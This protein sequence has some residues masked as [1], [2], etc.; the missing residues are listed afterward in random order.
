[1][2]AVVQRVSHASVTIVETSGLRESGRIGRGLL[3]LLGVRSDDTD[4]D[5]A[6]LADKIAGLRLFEDA[7]GR[8]NLALADVH[9]SVLAVPNFTL[10]A[11]CRKGRRPS[12]ADAASGM[13]AENLFKRF[14]AAVAAHGIPVETGEFGAD[15]RVALENAGPVTIV[16]DSPRS[17]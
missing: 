4:E 13:A 17:A 5:A 2:R 1:M 12:F 7:D 14:S 6:W 9:G 3:V 11:D 15:M 16:V 8:L 10:Y